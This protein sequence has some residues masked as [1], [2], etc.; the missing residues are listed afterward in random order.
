M[1][2]SVQKKVFYL[3]FFDFCTVLR[4]NTDRTSAMILCTHCRFCSSVHTATKSVFSLLVEI[5]ATN[6]SIIVGGGTTST[7]F[8]YHSPKQYNSD[9]GTPPLLLLLVLVVARL[10]KFDHN[11][12][13]SPRIP[14][15][16]LCVRVCFER[17]IAL[18]S[19][20]GWSRLASQR[21]LL[22]RLW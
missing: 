17:S 12:P 8:Q 11:S 16:L 4:Y 5:H 22:S 13:G 9:T 1:S 14:P 3:L 20:L 19:D 15:N 7:H 6:R 2:L 18:S 10:H 21:N